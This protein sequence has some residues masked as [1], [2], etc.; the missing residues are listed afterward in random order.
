MKRA[1]TLVVALILALTLTM[2]LDP[3]TGWAATGG[4]RA[5]GPSGW[6]YTVKSGDTLYLM[7]KRFGSTVPAI[8]K[9]NGLSG[10]YLTVGQVLTIPTIGTVGAGSQGNLNSQPVSRGGTTGRSTLPARYSQGDLYWLAK[11]IYAESRGESFEGQVAVGAVILNRLDNPAFPKTIYSIIFE[12]WD[13]LYYQFSPVAD[14]SIGLEPN[15]LAYEAARQAMGGYDP[16]RGALYFYEPTKS[17]SKWILTRPVITK[18][19]QHI[20]AG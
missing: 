14:G 16:S 9:A 17:T 8:Q 13:G 10:W 4:I 11:I 3:A 5:I 12:K 18:I 20:F 19:G 7:A 2:T 15:E 1:T 6:Q